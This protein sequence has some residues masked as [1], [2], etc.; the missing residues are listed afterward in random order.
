MQ[1][2]EGGKEVIASGTVVSAREAPIRFVLQPDFQVEVRF[3]YDGPKT[4]RV[5]S[6]VEGPALV[7]TISNF[8]NSLGTSTTEPLQIGV[9]DGSYI[10]LIFA[11]YYIGDEVR[12]SIVFHYTFLKGERANKE[13]ANGK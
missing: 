12:H 4:Q 8:E 7:I 5:S 10:S 11:L 13:V 3:E 6:K 9:F 2:L 1:I